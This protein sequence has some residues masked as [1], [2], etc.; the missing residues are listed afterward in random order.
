MFIYRVW[1]KENNKSFIGYTTRLQI[2]AVIS[3]LYGSRKGR[4]ASHISKVLGFEGKEKFGIEELTEMP[5]ESSAVD[6]DTKLRE[7][8]LDFNSY[9]PDGYNLKVGK[10][11]GFRFSDNQRERLNE[12]QNR[13]EVNLKKNATRKRNQAKKMADE[14][15]GS[16]SLTP[17]QIQ[18][19]T[20]V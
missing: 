9:Y 15:R 6:I 11:E 18:F 16:P 13:R 1:N 20:L 17:E 7:Y 5:D 4:N 14:A 8:I 10:D 2:G 19:P 12:I 3:S